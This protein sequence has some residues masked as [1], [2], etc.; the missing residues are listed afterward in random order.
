MRVW[1]RER[2][3]GGANSCGLESDAAAGGWIGLDAETCGLTRS[4]GAA[5]TLMSGF[6]VDRTEGKGRA[7]RGAVAWADGLA[8]ARDRAEMGF[9]TKAVI[10]AT[11]GGCCRPAVECKTKVKM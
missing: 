6:C 10:V 5:A 2:R 8:A 3:D 7:R 1:G 11:L 9:G 4:G